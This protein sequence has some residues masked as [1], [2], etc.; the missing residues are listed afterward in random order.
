MLLCLVIGASAEGGSV[1]LSNYATSF[2]AGLFA[3][4]QEGALP[5]YVE[6]GQSLFFTL[7]IS[8]FNSQ[9]LVAFLKTN[10]GADFTIPLDFADKIQGNYPTEIDPD[11]FDNV[12]Y[13]NGEKL[14]RWWIDEGSDVVRIRFDEE[15][16]NNAGSNTVVENVKLS[17]DGTL[18]VA[19]KGDDGKVVFNAAGKAFPLQ[20]KTGY[21]LKKQ[22]GVPY[23]SAEAA[24]YVTDYTVTL[25]LDQNMMLSGNADLYTAAL[26]LVDTV[27]NGGALQ[28]AIAGNVSVTAPAGETAAAAISNNG[29]V[30][31]LTL[32][33]PDQKLN[34]GKY[35]F[36]YKMKIT[37]AA[38]AAKLANYTEAQ[39]TNTVELKENASS[40]KTP[41]T[42]EATIAWENVTD[43]QFKID[44]GAFTE[45]APD[46]KGVYWDEETD[47]YYI[48]FRVVVYVREPVSTF[49]VTDHPNYSLSFRNVP[50]TPKLEGVDTSAGFWSN[51]ISTAVL[52]NVNATVT[53]G[54]NDKAE[55]VITVT[56]PEGQKLAPGAYH[57]RVPADVTGAVDTTLKNSYPQSYSNTA[58]L[59]SV[60]G[61]PTSEN[62]EFKQAIPNRTEPRKDGG[63]AVDSATGELLFY[64]GK[65]VIRWDVWFGWDFYDETTFV[66]TLSGMELLV[67]RDYPFEIHSFT[68]QNHRKERLASLTTTTDTDYLDFNEAKTQFTFTNENLGV[69]SDGTPVKL[70]K[71]VYFTTPLDADNELGYVNTGLSNGYSITHT[72][73]G[74]DGFGSGPITGDVTPDMTAQ[75]RLYVRKKHVIE[76][77]DSLTKWLITCDNVNKIPFERLDHLDII[78]L[79]PQAQNQG[80]NSVG[81]TV[82]YSDKWPIKVE[83]TTGKGTKIPLVEGT[84]YT[85]VKRHDN[86]DF[87]NDGEKGFA[88]DLNMDTVA[89]LLSNDG[90]AFFKVIDVTCYLNNAVYSHGT[91][92][93]IKNDGW[94]DYSNQGVELKD[95]VNAEYTRSFAKRIKGAVKYG[96]NYDPNATRAYYVCPPYG[97]IPDTMTYFV[98]K[99]GYGS[100]ALDGQK[101]IVWRITLGARAF[102]HN[103]EPLVVTVT[104]TIS[105]NQKFPSYPGKE[106]MDQFLIRNGDYI[107]IPDSLVLNGN[108][109]TLAFTVPVGS[110]VGGN[111]EDSETLYIYYHTILKPEALQEALDAAGK[112]A[113]AFTIEY[114]N[115]ASASWNGESAAVPTA[116][117]S[118][119]FEN[120]VLDKTAKFMQSAGNK[121]SYT[122]E[123]NPYGLDLQANSDV[124]LLEDV[125]GAG[126]DVFAYIPSSFKVTN[127]DTGAQLSRS[128]AASATTYKLVMS[129]DGKSFMLDVP[130]NTHLKL[131]YQVKTTQPVGT[132]DVSLLNNAS[133]AG[134][135][136]QSE[137]IVF[138][139]SS[140]YQS[141]SFSVLPDEAGIR[142][143]KISSEGADS[144]TPVPLAGAEFTVTQL[145]A[146]FAQVGQPQKM[147][148]TANG[149]IEIKQKLTDVLYM[150]I[151]ETQ[152]PAGYRLG[153]APW[154]WCYALVPSGTTLSDEDKA[155]LKETVK[156]E[157]TVIPAG[158]YVEDSITNDPVSLLVRKVDETNNLLAG[159]TLVLKDS[160]G[161][162]IAPE[163]NHAVSGEWKYTQLAAGNYT[164]SEEAAPEGYEKSAESPWTFTLNENG[165]MEIAQAYDNLSISDDGACLIVIN[166]P[167]AQTVSVTVTKAWQKDDDTTAPEGATVVFTLLADDVATDYTVMLDGTADPAP[168]AAGGYESEAWKAT[169]VNLPKCE[170]DTAA[171]IVY[172]VAE[173]TGRAGYVA[174]PA[175]PV[176]DGATITNTYAVEPVT[177]SFPVQK[178]LSVP[179]GMK[180]PADWSYTIDVAAN[181]GAPVADVMIGTVD[182]ANATVT[183]GPFTYTAPGTYTYTV[184]ETG[185]VAGVTNDSS[186]SGK[187]VTVIVTDNGDGTLT[188]EAS[189]TENAPLVF[190]NTYGLSS[191]TV[192]F[193]VQKV[194]DVPEGM[195]GPAEWS[196][197][198]DVAANDGAPVAETMSSTVSNTAD[199]VTFGPITYTAPGT[200]TYTVKENGTVAGVTNDSSASG[201]TVTVTVTDNG[202]GTL[203]ATANSTDA[204]P[205]TFTNTYAIEPVT[206]SFPVHKVLEVPAG[207]EGPAEWSYDITVTAKDGAPVADV[208]TGTVNETN[209]TVTFGP[210]TYTAPGTYTYTVTENGEVAGV[211]NDEE[212]TKTVTVTVTDN[213]DGTLTAE[214]SATENNPLTFTNN[215][216]VEPVEIALQ[217]A[218]KITGRDLAEGEFSFTLQEQGSDMTLTAQNAA[219]GTVVF[220]AIEY[221]EVGEYTYIISETEGEL[222]GVTY[223]SHSVTATVTVND[224]GKGALEATAE[225]SGETTFV[226]TYA[227]TGE[228]I[229]VATKTVNGAEPREDEQFTFEL[230]DATG[231]V[232]QTKQN[233]AGEITFDALNYTLEDANKS[234][235]YKVRE[236]QEE[237]PGYTIDSTEYAVAVWVYDNG[238]GTLKVTKTVVSNGEPKEAMSFNNIYEAEGEWK[239]TSAKTVNGAEPREDQVYEFTLTDAEG[240]TILAENAKG[241]IAF[242]SLTYGLSDAG[243]TYT[244]TVKEITTPTDLLATDGSVYTVDVTVTDNKDGTLDVKP[245]ITKD[246]EEVETIT[247][248]N[249]LT[250]LLTISKTVE[251]VDTAET[252]PFTVKLYDADG[253]EAT[254]EYAY[255]GDAE[256]MLKSGDAIE[257]A[258]GQSVT[259]SGLLPGMKYSVVEADAIA[260]ETAVNGNA[261]NTAEG[262]LAEENNEVAFVN[263]YKTTL[264]MVKKSWQGG[265]GGAIELTLYA[266]GEKLQPQPMYTREENTYLYTDL[267][268]YDEQDQPIVYSAKE[269]Y[270]DGFLTIYSNVAPYADE[271]KAIYDGGTIINKAIIKADF[272]VKK[273][274][275]GLAEGEAA[276][277]I[278]LVLY[279]NGVATD[280]KTPDPDRNG[281]YKYYDLPG[282][283]DDQPAV[284]TVKELP[285]EG[286]ETSYKLANGA[287]A[288]YAD[289]GGTITNAKIPQTGD[290]APLA[291]WL[292][293]LGASATMLMLLLKRRKA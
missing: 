97:P 29:T 120:V 245:V 11:D 102:S 57:L 129:E 255:T 239:L 40:L 172:T 22:A 99:G 216:D 273:E 31:T 192:S 190:T 19:D 182:E 184:T 59:T 134:R 55:M 4:Q 240:N 170:E 242:D 131:T 219:D 201:K 78:D 68:D 231:D 142:L 14:F 278:E 49:T 37:P 91:E 292:T 165:N 62:K 185:T 33:S 233:V 88:V 38:A 271:T 84:H 139:V 249:I 270:V 247:F 101:E 213:G 95:E 50:T 236:K 9:E 183:F 20:M 18:N 196:Y 144:D 166:E 158:S 263:K 133:L 41:L 211:T 13:V 179:E 75:G 207:M 26:T 79:V 116:K 191:T 118:A 80:E 214:A 187:N 221:T 147:T 293:L 226:N 94:L 69:N 289:N 150:V 198:I 203:T 152:A 76:H 246:E 237:K 53:S 218:K 260:F 163:R 100:D 193:P 108:T 86:Y 267:P 145:D 280:Y 206:A 106:L 111:E 243:K 83:L 92:K 81:A 199:T 112:D 16:I 238:D 234:F 228:L 109:F 272:S 162:T 34:K 174:S 24:S 223:D 160:S 12:A 261:G 186:A 208:M 224:N 230:C 282:E 82:H 253:T 209:A 126:K 153:A 125:M 130:D 132:K 188:A 96:E 77:T 285:A 277:A 235:L 159:A 72:T 241:E 225:Y 156:C 217:V 135:K 169:F 252:F 250:T 73:L 149:L 3:N 200:Y 28:G 177:A 195:E 124:I 121:V 281:W 127:L 104:D 74:G 61:Q 275:S 194:L 119:T 167:V 143:V 39:K 244:Y 87:G 123:M 35:T 42:A 90:S 64:N 178:V 274:W 259:I 262:T 291:M 140:A 180:G 157:V 46:Y 251:G 176:A 257:L 71:M 173:T 47:K 113:N 164:L 136:P 51:D 17:F 279:C 27:E 288:E 266:N 93:T 52:T 10:P 67:N 137:S 171:E 161:N 204:E 220:P 63:Y 43:N 32:S 154:K 254:G 181:D 168:T 284:Y 115:T 5:N 229:L 202:D 1:P 114:T 269:K 7:Q 138:D 122:V 212:T 30:N 222:G 264:F 70:Y 103:T 232:L 283:V 256:G 6:N 44:K 107:I 54:L 146:S 148:T 210:F 258:H 89:A 290:E 25:E 151:E 21:T 205:L 56:A 48:D 65:P 2:S 175:E 287:S 23:Y 15:W 110:W 58:Y 117:D 215:Y 155:G 268:M 189:A 248:E 8:D 265:G 98:G 45:K 128:S 141:G 105:D 36:T 197:T 66:D 227:A 286:Y 276:P 85:I 60:D